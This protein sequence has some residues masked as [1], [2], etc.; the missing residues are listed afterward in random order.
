MQQSLLIKSLNGL[1]E[2]FGLGRICSRELSH[3]VS[4]PICTTLSMV[5]ADHLQSIVNKWGCLLQCGDP[6]SFYCKSYWDWRDFRTQYHLNL[7]V[8]RLFAYA[9]S[10]YKSINISFQFLASDLLHDRVF[11]DDG[12]TDHKT[13][14]IYKAIHLTMNVVIAPPPSFTERKVL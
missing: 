5:K 9:G 4:Y 1:H 13:K 14:M 7:L 11:L 12:S 10:T 2:L 8:Q 6:K 3:I